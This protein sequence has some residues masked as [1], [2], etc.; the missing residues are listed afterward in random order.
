[1]HLERVRAIAVGLLAAGVLFLCGYPALAA[2]ASLGH[3]QPQHH[4]ARDTGRA[5]RCKPFTL[6]MASGPSPSPAA[7]AVP[8]IPS[9]S[10]IATTPATVTTTSPGTPS[11]AAAGAPPELPELCVS[12]R[13]ATAYVPRGRPAA[14]D[15]QVWT[16]HW[17]PAVQIIVTLST[18]RS[19][20]RPEFTTRCH[21]PAHSPKRRLLAACVT[22]APSGK[23][24]DLRA[25]VTAKPGAT[26]VGLTARAAYAGAAAEAASS[27]AAPT[28]PVK[29]SE[30]VRIRD[31]RPTGPAV[32]GAA[33][34]PVTIAPD[35]QGPLP[36]LS[37]PELNATGPDPGQ[38]NTV[39]AAGSVSG[40]FPAIRPA[41]VQ[42]LDVAYPRVGIR[43]P[44]DVPLAD[45]V[46]MR[47]TGTPQL[48]EQIAGFAALA[49]AAV[50]GL[51]Q[52]AVRRLR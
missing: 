24:T 18:S 26:A 39:V 43:W 14:F 29:V 7:S 31:M 40:L 2:L 27:A 22:N 52:V 21:E 11:P 37:T 3:G 49:L 16:E 44:Q 28:R 13:R 45:S 34:P 23:H 41:S 42:G 48:A 33:L 36:D 20:Q 50:L 15:V 6:A 12:I 9:P 47:K 51:T 32:Q 19:G 1:M 30:T 38:A 8:V 35:P 25:R 46:P 10:A 17:T 5:I 4:S